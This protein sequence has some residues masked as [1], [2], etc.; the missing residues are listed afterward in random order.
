M[1]V[2]VVVQSQYIPDQ[3][4]FFQQCHA[5]LKPGGIIVIHMIDPEAFP[6]TT[7]RRISPTSIP[8]NDGAKRESDGSGKPSKQ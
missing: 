7:S 4:R 1:D 2:R 6:P 5:W 3:K 8:L